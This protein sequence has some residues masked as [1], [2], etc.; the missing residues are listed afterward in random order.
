MMNCTYTY[1]FNER[2]EDEEKRER[3]GEKEQTDVTCLS[4]SL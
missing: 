1:I 3:A 2:G 4:F